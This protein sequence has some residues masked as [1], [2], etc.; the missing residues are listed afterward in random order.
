[1]GQMA[2][3]W[4][5]GHLVCEAVM[6][7]GDAWTPHDQRADWVKGHVN[8]DTAVTGSQCVLVSVKFGLCFEY[9]KAQLVTINDLWSKQAR[10]CVFV[11]HCFA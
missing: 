8:S 2:R 9:K 10:P 4:V 11:P 3:E 1:M 6:G 5:G 7:W